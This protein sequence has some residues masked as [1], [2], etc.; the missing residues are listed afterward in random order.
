METTAIGKFQCALDDDH[1]FNP[2]C[3]RARALLIARAC[4]SSTKTRADMVISPAYAQAATAADPVAG[5]L[6]GGIIPM[7]LIFVI[8]YFLMIRP[9]QTAMKKHREKIAAVKKGDSVVT[10]GGL[11]AKVTRVDDEQVE[12]EIAN[13]VKV[14][15]IKGTLSDV[16]PL[17]SVKPAND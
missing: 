2:G 8:F 13:G 12:V 3:A 10:G 7:I 17:G 5:F 6:T 9:Q 11:V 1:W 4:L 14:K 16:T 15:A